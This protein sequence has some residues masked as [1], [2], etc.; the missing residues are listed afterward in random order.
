MNLGNEELRLPAGYRCN[1]SASSDRTGTPYW[2]EPGHNDLRYQ[3]PVYR[4]AARRTK[5]MHADVVIDVGCGSGDKLQ[6]FLTGTART[7]VGIDQGS[8]IDLARERHPALQWRSGDLDDDAFWDEHSELTP[9]LVICADVIEH[10]SDPR[11]LLRH[12]KTLTGD[13]LLLLSTPDRARLDVAQ[14]GPP[15][16]PRHVREWTALEFADLATT[17][18]FRILKHH[19]LLPRQYSASVLDTKRVVWRALHRLPIPDRRSCQV[20]ELRAA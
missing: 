14:M 1:P 20:L 10:L 8:G 6:R 15:K 19:H 11:A 16:N 9:D 12:L 17:S 13:G 18:G 5:A 4:L 3:V 2:E 7:V